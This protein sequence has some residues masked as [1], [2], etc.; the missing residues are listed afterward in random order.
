MANSFPIKCSLCQTVIPT[1][2]LV[3]LIRRYDL[4]QMA[5]S[6]LANSKTLMEIYERTDLQA[7]LVSISDENKESVLSC[8]LCG[9]YV[10]VFVPMQKDYWD[11]LE[12]KRIIAIEDFKARMAQKLR[13][14]K[15]RID[16]NIAEL[17]KDLVKIRG[18]FVSE[19]KSVFMANR[20]RLL[21]KILE[22]DPAA[23]VKPL[24][25]NDKMNE[26]DASYVEHDIK[27]YA[28]SKISELCSNPQVAVEIDQVFDD[29][30]GLSIQDVKIR[31][32]IR[33]LMAEKSQRSKELDKQYADEIA[34]GLKT[35]ETTQD[36]QSLGTSDD[37]KIEQSESTK[38]FVCQR[39]GCSG[40]M[41]IACNSRFEKD[42]I[43]KHICVSQK[44]NEIYLEIIDI[45][46]KASTRVCPECQFPGM[47]EAFIMQIVS[48]FSDSLNQVLTSL[49]QS[50]E[51]DGAIIAKPLKNHWEA[52]LPSII[53]GQFE[54]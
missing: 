51:S 45:L 42:E 18:K 36:V 11:R 54:L 8:H 13:E 46:A 6:E 53:N 38:F 2:H 16:R 33:A 10:E 12:R 44:E 28:E 52:L 41:C 40:A 22:I 20:R 37:L 26:E 34:S 17:Q 50:V 4:E 32:D 5:S 49:A 14:E 43:L 1:H 15:K 19:Y 47:K 25:L 35:L 48:D 24:W 21:L 23:S 7:G 3:P 29:L 30:K 39:V 31:S 9:Q 27:A